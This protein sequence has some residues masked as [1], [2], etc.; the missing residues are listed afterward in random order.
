MNKYLS[1]ENQVLN[2]FSKKIEISMIYF[3]IKKR[4][5]NLHYEN[6]VSHKSMRTG[7]H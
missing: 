3:L 7:K 6:E 5:Y 2:F 4:V 1:L